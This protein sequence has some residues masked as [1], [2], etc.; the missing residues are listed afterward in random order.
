MND[1]LVLN[2]EKHL[3]HLTKK[4]YS[5]TYINKNIIP[6][7]NYIVLSKNNKFLIG[8]SQGIGKSTLVNVIQK[9]IKTFYNKRVLTL[10]LDDYYLSRKKRFVLSNKI[11]PLLITR[12]VPGTHD[13]KKLI[14][15]INQFNRS[16]YPINIPI[17][18]KL[19][20]DT[21]S[22]NRKAILKADILILEGWCCGTSHIK[23]EFLFK[24][25][26]DLE[27]KKDSKKIWRKYYN[28]KLKTEY[29]D[30]FKMFD[31]TIFLKA[32]SF[33]FIFNWRMKQEKMIK[34]N[35]RKHKRMKKKSLNNFIEH[36]EKITKWMLKTLGSKADLVVKVNKKQNIISINY[37]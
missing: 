2:I 18:D 17:F 4:K 32:P 15:H 30:L 24:N 6:I 29:R 14:R 9:I 23:N 31:N 26:N 21:I 37:N 12:G 33:K 1:K 25:L 16:K 20:D 19:I 35:S 11:H 28:E 27:R 36:Y 10:S 7:I 13:I 34:S 5:N 3:F 8:G 22:N